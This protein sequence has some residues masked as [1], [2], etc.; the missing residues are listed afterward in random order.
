[1]GSKPS[2]FIT[3]AGLLT[4]TICQPGVETKS[5]FCFSKRVVSAL[6]SVR[7]RV[8]IAASSGSEN[9]QGRRGEVD[10][11]LQQLIERVRTASLDLFVPARGQTIEQ[12]GEICAGGIVSLPHLVGRKF[13]LR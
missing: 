12:H 2:T 5:D 1:M 8:A 7:A 13:V 10:H 9:A 11:R 6:M 3:P 4:T